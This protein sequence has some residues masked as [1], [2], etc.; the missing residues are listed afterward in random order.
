MTAPILVLGDVLVDELRTPAGSVDVAGGSA[1]N[2]AVGLAVLGVP[3]VLAGMVGDDESGGMLR[4]HAAEHGV[5]LLATDAP[6]GTGRA[7]SDRTA[8]EPVYSFSPASRSRTLVP[9][10]ALRQAAARA[11]L[12]VVSGFPFDD[13]A[14]VATLRSLISGGAGVAIDANPRPG[15]LRDRDA[16]LAGLLELSDGAA[17][18]KLGADD[19]EL[20]FPGSLGEA[21]AR[22]LDAGA[23]TVLETSGGDGAAL[24]RRTGRVDVPIAPADGDVVDTMGAGDAVFATVVAALAADTPDPTAVLRRAMAV[25]AATIRS[26]G[27][28]L[29]LPR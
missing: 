9:S 23:Q 25:A 17:L 16:F 26:S 18:V 12:L 8:G 28:L 19:A 13:P 15:L 21:T 2:V 24:V 3:S 7:V 4:R 29:R 10:E 5:P 22:V 6:L 14:E 20:L 1:L 11:R 27:G